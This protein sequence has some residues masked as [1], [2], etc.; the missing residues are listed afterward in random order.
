[1]Y[2]LVSMDLDETLLTRDKKMSPDFP[3]F[4]EEL[5]EK[6]II[7]IVATGR[8]FTTAK[9]FVGD[10]DIDL[11]CNNGNLIRN[12]KHGD[13]LYVNPISFE[14][15][16]RVMDLDKEKVLSCVLHVTGQKGV[17]LAFPDRK[18]RTLDKHYANHFAG[19]IREV[20]SI[21]DLKSK[22]L[23][24]VFTGDDQ[25]LFKLYEIL[26]ENISEDFNLH[27][28]SMQSHKGYMLEVLQKNGDKFVGVSIYCE[29]KNIDLKDIIAI[30]DDSNDRNLI[31]NAGFGIA[32]K[33]G[34]QAVKDVAKLI[35]KKDNN[36]NGAI[37]IL[38][39]VLW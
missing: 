11:I 22:V 39:E 1:M 3:A 17:D 37:E 13:I 6:N 27:L 18:T 10:V 4:V 31:A 28:M 30:G 34:V 14:D 7:P 29:K 21:E 26:K 12:S 5:K 8:E 32:M 20:D 33:N 25:R 35:S 2:K 9:K 36:H 23:S 15:L 24:I 16:R 38:R 19:R